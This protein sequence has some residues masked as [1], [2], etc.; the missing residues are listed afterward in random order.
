MSRNF[1]RCDYITDNGSVAVSIARDQYV[2]PR[3]YD[4]ENAVPFWSK[5][6]VTKEI[7]YYL[8]MHTCTRRAIST[9][10]H[11][12]HDADRLLHQLRAELLR[13]PARPDPG[14]LHSVLDTDVNMTE[15]YAICDV[16]NEDGRLAC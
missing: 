1:S 12:G 13:R 2:L 14:P 7:E 3:F 6:V 8:L 5:L 9:L 16:R 15:S 4:L 11:V 10:F